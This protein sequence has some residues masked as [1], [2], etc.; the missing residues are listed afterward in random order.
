V[1]T[2]VSDK[3]GSMEWRLRTWETGSN[4][5]N[6]GEEKED[7]KLKETGREGA[8]WHLKNNTTKGGG[9][10]RGGG[11]G[12]EIGGSAQQKNPTRGELQCVRN[13]A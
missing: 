11:G 10:G 8:K 7:N 3:E 4:G 12:G 13:R 6:K 9:M 5:T 2:G 1:S